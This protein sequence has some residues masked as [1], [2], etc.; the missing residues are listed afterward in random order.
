M[1]NKIL[2]TILL[3]ILLLI[4][5]IIISNLNFHNYKQKIVEPGVKLE[6]KKLKPFNRRELMKFLEELKSQKEIPPQNAHLAPNS[7]KIISE[8]YGKTLKSEKMATKLLKAKTGSQINLNFKQ[9]KPQITTKFITNNQL[10]WINFKN[11]S[12]KIKVS[13]LSTYTTPIKNDD[14]P[15]V[16]NIEVAI[17]KLNGIIIKPQEKFSFNEQIGE[18]TPEN[19]YK[20]APVIID[21]ELQPAY[22]GGICQVSSTLYNTLL[23]SNLK[24]IERHPHSLPVSYIPAGKDATIVP[25]TKDLQFKNNQKFPLTIWGEVINNKVAIFLL[26]VHKIN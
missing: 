10:R 4:F 2:K 24:I 18:I 13:L 14:K 21:N 11:K 6:E 20:K 16:N 5:P 12:I 23:K 15:R 3:T 19:G 22:G 25:G 9:V 8:K 7:Q 17:K 26:R 1:Q